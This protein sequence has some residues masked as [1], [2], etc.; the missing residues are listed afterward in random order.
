MQSVKTIAPPSA[1]AEILS[2]IKTDYFKLDKMMLRNLSLLIQEILKKFDVAIEEIET[3][4]H[5]LSAETI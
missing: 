2:L 1:L 4:Q 3:S 5:S